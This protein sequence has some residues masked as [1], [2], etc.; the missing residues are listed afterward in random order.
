MRGGIVVGEVVCRIIMGCMSSKN[1]GVDKKDVNIQKGA[2]QSS[3][4][5]EQS[6]EISSKVNTSATVKPKIQVT[7]RDK[8][9]LDLK[10]QRDLLNQLKKRTELNHDRETKVSENEKGAKKKEKLGVFL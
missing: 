6:T 2:A 10:H 1:V 7:E 4:T 3:F 9:L 5:Q 8:A